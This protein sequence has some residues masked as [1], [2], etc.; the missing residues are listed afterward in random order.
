[1]TQNKNSSDVVIIG[2]VAAGPKT[3]AVL[4]RRLADKKITLFQKEEHISYGTC[5]MPYFAS[6][7]INSF[8]ELTFTS[9]GVPRTPDFF[10]HSKG[11]EVLTLSEVIKI[12]RDRKT[13]TVK[14]LKDG[15][16]TEHGYGKLV[17]ATGSV[18]N[19][20]PFECADSPNIRPFTRPA[21][22]I[23]F[24]QAAQA[25]RVGKVVIIGGG[26]IGC[27]L[28]EAMVSMW[29]IETVLIEKEPQV[30]PYILDREMAEQVKHEMVR[31]DVEVM[32]GAAVEKV[33]L[34]A[35]GNTVVSVRDREPI[36][37]DYVFVCVGV[38]PETALAN[39][40]GLVIG[41]AGGIEVNDQMQTSDP[42]IYAGGDCV[43][44]RHQL[45]G[46]KIFMPMGSLANR[47]GRVIAENIAGNKIKFPG[48]VGSFLVK[49]FDINVGATGLSEQVALNH[50]MK[51]VSLWGAFPD[52]P[53]YYPESKTFTLKMVYDETDSR[54]LGLQAV[55]AGDICRRI[56]VFASF[57]QRQ[58]GTDD[59]L[60]FEPGYAPPYAEALD[61]LYHLASMTAAQKRGISFLKPGLDIDNLM[62]HND[63]SNVIGLDVR[64]PEEIEAQPW[65]LPE[66][67]KGQQVAI[68]LN[69]LR[70]RLEGLDRNKKILLMCRRG[71]R[72][73]Q[74]AHILRRAGFKDV[75]IVSGGAQASLL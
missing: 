18:P 58:A 50:G 55:G 36:T 27:E 38:H 60:D 20:P 51:A 14:N 53:D 56:D 47:H 45:T 1:M 39:E 44:L 22:A 11:F 57:L 7:D 3:A 15:K 63:F 43:E 74:A 4:A 42:D 24:R 19:R 32:T 26:F 30:L 54:L 49:V 31:Q 70:E 73:Y 28:V 71:P 41:E 16:I 61:P 13:V 40:C 66:K 33:T 62:E 8:E 25:G 21:D 64:E 75:H 34:D 23:H 69:D 52:K 65:T 12:D 59:L 46:E 72:S 5:G 10:R 2:G 67:F 17:I 35:D 68:P 9:Y 48:V 6:G 37:A 29:G